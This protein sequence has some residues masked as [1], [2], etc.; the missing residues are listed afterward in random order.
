MVSKVVI[1]LLGCCAVLSYVHAGSIVRQEPSNTTTVAPEEE[2]VTEEGSGFSVN[3]TEPVLV[4][5]DYVVVFGFNDTD[6]SDDDI[7]PT[8]S[9][10]DDDGEDEETV[11]IFD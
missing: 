7:F 6:A 11:I 10:Y 8:P 5:Y 1:F 4:V 2:E 9:D 3:Q